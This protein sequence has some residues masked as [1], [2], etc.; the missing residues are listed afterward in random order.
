MS[1]EIIETPLQ[2]Q[3]ESGRDL[4]SF[5]EEKG[6][7]RAL[8]DEEVELSASDANIRQ[9]LYDLTG[10]KGVM[11]GEE[12]VYDELS[13]P[14][15]QVGKEIDTDRVSDFSSLSSEAGHT[16]GL[17]DDSQP[18]ESENKPKRRRSIRRKDKSEGSEESQD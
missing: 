4:D 3:L 13:D 2:A 15:S 17:V 5:L 1:E 6:K 11:P 18:Q 10:E 9:D 14:S 8:K 7:R 12:V 16:E